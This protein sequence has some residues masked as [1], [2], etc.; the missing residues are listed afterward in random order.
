MAAIVACCNADAVEQSTRV[1]MRQVI[2]NW[3]SGN[4]HT[5]RQENRQFVMSAVNYTRGTSKRNAIW[6][7]NGLKRRLV[8]YLALN[9]YFW[10]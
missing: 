3:S 4:P 1:V 5:L 10:L 8:A 6:T 9:Q 2:E 7:L